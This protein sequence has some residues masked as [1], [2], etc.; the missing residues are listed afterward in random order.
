[1]VDSL[2]LPDL[3]VNKYYSKLEPHTPSD[4]ES[5]KKQV[6]ISLRNTLF[7]FG[8]MN[9]SESTEENETSQSFI[10][11]PINGDIKK[12]CEH[13]LEGKRCP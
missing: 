3:D 13:R 12:V 11:G 8:I 9:R 1:M 10:L 6:V 7:C 5:S 4:D 2:Q